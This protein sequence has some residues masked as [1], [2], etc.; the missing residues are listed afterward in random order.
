MALK[1]HTRKDLELKFRNVQ[2]S[3][4]VT[5]SSVLQSMV[6]EKKLISDKMS[7]SFSLSEGNKFHKTSRCSHIVIVFTM[8]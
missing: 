5:L 3:C 7:M 2:V 8:T 1:E 6:R 4:S